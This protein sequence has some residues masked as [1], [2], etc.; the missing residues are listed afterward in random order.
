MLATLLEDA[1]DRVLGEPVDLQV[2]VDL[3]QLS[4]DGDVAQRVPKPDR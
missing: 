1:G 2:G 4:G 3:A